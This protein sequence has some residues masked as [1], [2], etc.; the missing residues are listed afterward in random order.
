MMKSENLSKRYKSTI[1]REEKVN[2]M[3]NRDK[4]KIKRGQRKDK[5]KKTIYGCEIK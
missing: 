1:K 3:E 5:K 4:E 2:Q